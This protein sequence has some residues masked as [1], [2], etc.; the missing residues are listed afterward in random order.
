MY[1]LS[2]IIARLSKSVQILKTSPC[3]FSLRD[4]IF[5]LATKICHSSTSW[6]LNLRM[7]ANGVAAQAFAP[8]VAAV[9]TMQSSGHR[10]QKAEANNFLDK[11]QKTVSFQRV[12]S[13]RIAKRRL[14]QKRGIHR[15]PSCKPTIRPLT[16]RER[17]SQLSL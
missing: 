14:S 7:A 8:V 2:S 17:C 15:S 3:D 16:Y 6:A 9:E 10:A 13:S 11:F 12:P 4:L 5:L 1:F